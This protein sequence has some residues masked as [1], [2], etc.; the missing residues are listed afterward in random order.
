VTESFASAVL[1]AKAPGDAATLRTWLAG[2]G[3][4][5]TILTRP[6]PRSTAPPA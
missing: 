1:A 4:E 3:V 2:R 6:A 5:V